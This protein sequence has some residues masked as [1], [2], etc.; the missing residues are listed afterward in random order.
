MRNMIVVGSLTK[1]QTLYCIRDSCVNVYA[2]GHRVVTTQVAGG[3]IKV[4][5]NEYAVAQVAGVART[6]LSSSRTPVE[7]IKALWYGVPK[8]PNGLAKKQ[9]KRPDICPRTW[10]MME[11]CHNWSNTFR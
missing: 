11:K 9:V 8:D 7:T 2:P 6:Y 1:K 10:Q 5:G 3:E 4:S